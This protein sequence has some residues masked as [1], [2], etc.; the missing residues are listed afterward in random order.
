MVLRKPGEIPLRTHEGPGAVQDCIN[1]LKLQQPLPA[2]I[3]DDNI[4]RAC[5]DHA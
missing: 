3:W 2:L 4:A 1:F 5:R